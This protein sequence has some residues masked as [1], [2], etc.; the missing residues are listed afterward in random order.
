[1]LAEFAPHRA[2]TR[3]WRRSTR[4]AEEERRR[5]SDER[6][7]V[8]RELHD[9]LAH[10]ISLINV[11]A[12][13]ALHLMDEQPE[14]A[15]TALTAIK[16]ASK[17]ALGELRSVLGVLRAARRRGAARSRAHASPGS[18]RSLDQARAAGLDVRRRRRGCAAAAARRRST[19]PPSGSCRRRSPT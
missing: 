7:R 3:R 4:R 13:V 9:V 5:A 1:M 16:Q 14:Q 8:A 11:Q 15:R 19:S 12:G 10:N 17:D 18:T 2:A 6:L